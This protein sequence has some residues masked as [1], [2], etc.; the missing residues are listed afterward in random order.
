MSK[1]STVPLRYPDGSEAGQTEELWCLSLIPA[2]GEPESQ[3]MLLSEAGCRKY[4]AFFSPHSWQP[5]P[6]WA[7]QDTRWSES[8]SLRKGSSLV[9]WDGWVALHYNLCS[10]LCLLNGLWFLHSASPACVPSCHPNCTACSL[11]YSR[12]M[13]LVPTNPSTCLPHLRAKLSRKL[14]FKFRKTFDAAPHERSL[15]GAIQICLDMRDAVCFRKWV[16]NHKPSRMINSSLS[17]RG[18]VPGGVRQRSQVD[19]SFVTSTL[20][21]WKKK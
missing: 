20:T 15:W 13:L 2:K 18:D 5:H 19:P 6:E 4:M 3:G 11:G 14:Y 10:L 9:G 17:A 16:R 7:Q 21:S 8:S 12:E 1:G